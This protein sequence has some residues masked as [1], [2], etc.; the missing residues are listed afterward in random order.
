[1]RYGR[2][3]LITSL[4]G[5]TALG[6]SSPIFSPS[7]QKAL[8]QVAQELGLDMPQFRQLLARDPHEG[9]WMVA[10]AAR[11]ESD[12]I[13]AHIRQIEA[14]LKAKDDNWR[15]LHRDFQRFARRF[16]RRFDRV[17]PIVIRHTERYP[18]EWQARGI[19]PQALSNWAN[20]FIGRHKRLLS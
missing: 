15:E 11:A 16:K 7:D 10:T 6:T 17:F 19:E 1:M 8:T 20:G 9:L 13:L 2:L 14:A 3:L 18:H 4:L 12:I 5:A